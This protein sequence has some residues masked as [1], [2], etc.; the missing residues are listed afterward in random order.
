[1][2]VLFIFSTT[3]YGQSKQNLS[4]QLWERVQSCYSSFEDTNEDGKLDDKRIKT[5]IR[6]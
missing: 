6:I 2:I 4:K 5:D 1:M 3:A